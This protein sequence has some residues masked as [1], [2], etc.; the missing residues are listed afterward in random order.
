LWEDAA[1]DHGTTREG[2]LRYR[3]SRG[4][5]TYAARRADHVFTICEGLR[6]ELSS[7]G[8][9]ASRITVIPNGVDIEKF[10]T[11]GTPDPELSVALGLEGKTV[12][13][14]AGSFYGYEGL[15]LLVSAMPS[16][17]ASR[18]DVRLLLVGG[19]FQE[20][21]LRSQ[22]R[23]LGIADKV[24]FT[25][26][27]PHADVNRYYDLTDVLVYPRLSMRLTD[28]VTPLKPL[29]AMAQG[30]LV[31]ASDVGGHREM[32]RDGETGIL[33]NAGNVG[34]LSAKVVGLLNMPERW[35][36][37]REAGR[38]YVENERSWA[39]CVARYAPVYE[40]LVGLERKSA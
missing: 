3:I 26:R 13:G 30:K 19:G 5:E 32:L 2:S 6:G 12:L 35:G 40:R 33:F 4:L 15:G 1:V 9:P 39:A 18:P 14:F 21:A 28:L 11:G 38:R 27:V 24:C 36:A 31:V 16:I 25:G 37:L 7:R 29:E 10:S 23:D 22:V 8:L 20:D 17:L 34:D